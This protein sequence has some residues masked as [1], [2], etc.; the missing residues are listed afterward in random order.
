M[1]KTLTL[2]EEEMQKCIDFSKRSAESQ[3]PIEFGQKD[4]KARPV[5]EIARDNLIGKMAEAAVARMLREEYK[6]HVP[7]NFEIYPR[8]EWDDCDIQIK[9]WTIDIKST[10]IGQWLLFET[11]KLNMRVNQEIN[12][13][14]DAVIMCRTPWDKE[15]DTPIGSVELVG[16]ISTKTL[17][18]NKK[19]VHR[20]K[21]GDY[22]PNTKAKLQADNL[23][24]KFD[25]LNHDWDEIIKYMVSNKP[26]DLS[27]CIISI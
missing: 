5:D 8:G 26:P 23:A 3:Q 22:I 14:P 9:A 4:T 25:D 20:L 21:K 12:N 10:R 6:I 17:L 19:I 7:V 27:V 11:N 1:Y 13:L 24:V 18:T 2:T 15:S 16:A